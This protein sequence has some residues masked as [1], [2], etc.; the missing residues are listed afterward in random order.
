MAYNANRKAENIMLFENATVYKPAEDG[1]S[2]E[3]KQLVLSFGKCAGWDFYTM[4]GF[5]ESM[6]QALRVDIKD[7]F[8]S[9]DPS[10][11]PGRQAT[12]SIDG[13][14]AAVFGQIN[15][16]VAE[17]F[18]MPSDT[19]AA[20]IELDVLFDNRNTEKAFKKLP[21]FPAIERDI[22]LIA[23]DETECGTIISTIEKAGVKTLES[24]KV[25]DVYKGKGVEDGKKSVAFRLTLRHAEK[26]L[27]DEDADKAI[28]K[29][30]KKLSAELNIELRK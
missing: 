19:Y 10:F 14:T 30:L 13:K 28:E 8:A 27:N 15:P 16:I 3:R 2:K 21:A 11:H 6:F 24:V 4:K 9:Q 25:F 17:N 20:V 23:D 29:I 7:V 5:V 18:S 12:I 26:T 1:M 22:A